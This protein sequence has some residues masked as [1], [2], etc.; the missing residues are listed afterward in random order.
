MTTSSGT[1]SEHTSSSQSQPTLQSSPY[2]LRQNRRP[3]WK[4]AANA[5]AYTCHITAANNPYISTPISG[6]YP[7]AKVSAEPT[8]LKQALQHPSEHLGW[9]SGIQNELASLETNQTWEY[10]ARSTLPTTANILTSKWVFKRKLSSTNAP[11]RYKARLVIRGFQQIDG[12]DYDETY[13]PVAKLTSLRM[14]L[15]L[16]AHFDW[17]I[18]QL[19]VVTA[20][21]NPPI[22]ENVYMEIPSGIKLGTTQN[23]PP[24]S[25]HV[26]KLRKALYGLKQAPRLWYQHIDRFLQS[27]GFTRST[28]DPNVYIQNG[29]SSNPHDRVILLLYVDDL[30]LFGSS[31]RR[32]QQ[33]KEL[34]KQQYQMSDL[35]P[36]QQFL[37]LQIQRN[38]STHTITLHQQQY[39]RQVLERFNY[40]D[41]F[42]KQTPL[43]VGCNLQ[44]S[45]SSNA[46]PV[47]NI[48]TYQALIGS[49]MWIMLSTRP[50]LAYTV[51]TLSKFNALPSHEHLA[52]ARH[53]LRYLKGTQTLGLTYSRTHTDTT[54]PYGPIGYSDSDF[55][56]DRT[57]RKS[58][59]GYVFT[60]SGAA[61]SWSSRKQP[62]VAFST[63]E[64]E[65]VGASIAAKEC[66]WIRHLYNALMPVPTAMRMTDKINR[67]QLLYLDNQ[68]AIKLAANPRF[69]ERTKHISIRFHFVRD[70]CE[71]QRIRI[72]YL[73]S[74]DMIADIMTKPL[75]PSTHNKHVTA[76]GLRTSTLHTN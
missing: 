62:I 2:Q 38:R 44:P 23:V 24:P 27:I 76:M 70:A 7:S 20:F 18:E 30:L 64:A 22:D 37:G 3:T 45:C 63:V 47:S 31:P 16:A 54:T 9:L 21:L 59:S 35:G 56:G 10:V 15:A 57:D 8:T 12:I 66:I 61:I 46:L 29:D 13:A 41:C 33:I 55:A 43:A 50:D 51:S 48:S 72:Q 39:I 34:L 49:L 68:G 19:D 65:Y 53:S 36:A 42:P 52:A 26:V 11:I 74:G 71:Q 5:D 40:L 4:A 73:P 58:T 32:I 1:A 25:T 67:I 17:E 69:H 60:L 75:P 28:A 14:L 6:S